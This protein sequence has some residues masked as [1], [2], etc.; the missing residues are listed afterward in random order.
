[1]DVCLQLGAR[2]ITVNGARAVHPWWQGTCVKYCKRVFR[3][4]EGDGMLMKIWSQYGYTA[5]P[6][7]L[8]CVMATLLMGLCR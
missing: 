2:A 1:M 3:W 5:A 6:S 7:P 8:V 4:A